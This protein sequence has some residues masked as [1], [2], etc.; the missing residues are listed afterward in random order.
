MRFDKKYAYNSWLNKHNKKIKE[1]Q[2][3]ENDKQLA[4]QEKKQEDVILKGTKK[5]V[6]AIIDS[7]TLREKVRE[8]KKNLV[9]TDN[10]FFFDILEG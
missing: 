7:T 10:E 3:L 1:F 6:E 8:E 5:I 4:F 9:N 2:S